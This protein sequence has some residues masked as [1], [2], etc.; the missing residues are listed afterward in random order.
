MTAASLSSL[1][2]PRSIAVVGASAD[3]S[4]IGG[5]P[6]DYLL[7][8]GFPGDIYP[9][10]PHR[11]EVQGLRSYARL[12]DISA[13]VDCALLV[14]PA[15]QVPDAAQEALRKG[16]R[17]LVIFSAGFAEVGEAG[18]LRQ[19]QMIAAA[20][21]QG[22]RV[23]GPNCLGA[24]NSH[25]NVFLTFSGVFDD[26]VGTR[27]RHGFVGQSGGFAGEIVKLAT[28]RDLAFGT[29]LSTG[30]EADIEL[31]EALSWLAQDAHTDVISL[32]IEGIRNRR[33]FFQGL[34][35]A[36]RRGKP[37]IALKVGRTPAGARAVASHTAGLAGADDIYDAVFEEFGVY[38]ARTTEEMLDV[39][40][41]CRRGRFPRARRLAI[42]TNSGG[43]GALSADT[44]HD[45]GLLLPAP[46]QAM[47][48]EILRMSPHAGVGNPVD[49]T[50]QV[51]N[52]PTLFSR[53]LTRMAGS[54]GYDAA[55]CF[56]GLI[57][58]MPLL[59][60]R[61]FAALRDCPAAALDFPMVLSVTAPSDMV[62]RYEAAGF[63]VFQDPVR[64]VR[65][66]AALVRF[67]ESFARG[68]DVSVNHAGVA[69]ISYGESFDERSAKALL[70]GIG[71]RGPAEAVAR[72]PEEAQAV[73]LRIGGRLAIKVLSPDI[74]HKT[75]VGGV[76]LHVA[77]SDA[78]ATVRTMAARV[79]AT[80]PSARIDGYLISPL[81]DDAPQFFIGAHADPTFGPVIVV[82]LGGTGVELLRDVVCARAPVSPARART[83]LERLRSYPL[84]SGYRGRRP[85]DVAALVEGIV[86]VS[87]LAHANPAVRTIEVNPAAVLDEG[88]GIVALD[89]V[90]E[91]FGSSEALK[92][93]GERSQ[94]CG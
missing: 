88:Q 67:G 55:Y 15:E 28:S 43:N 7:R 39:M 78:A 16:V 92:E 64:A 81:L 63:L 53:T 75:D 52:D 50:A 56:I 38:R 17:S 65:A 41:A 79:G 66:L 77:A 23:L 9:V 21:A 82:G 26:V 90:I 1:L 73:A 80:A 70:A 14:L 72:T 33:T 62:A 59:A 49:L 60:E 85:A 48:E 25:D 74:L 84:L 35:E 57:A 27:G 18:A 29:W 13:A 54:G 45:A 36:R 34:D 8:A 37:V 58:G 12:A 42:I 24:Y 47:C 87:R 69:Q 11:E 30:N 44:A 51:A 91:T 94:T 68:A 19:R 10:N 83:L 2:N 6:L 32:F 20:R 22:T 5:R 46:S 89:A 71:F 93:H 76:A 40:Y 61:V 3:R 31:G 4:R 86:L